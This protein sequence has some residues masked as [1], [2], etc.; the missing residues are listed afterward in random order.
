M[1]RTLIIFT[2]SYPWSL[3]LED[4]F[5]EPELS[6]LA[7]RFP[8]IILIPSQSKGV[9][10]NT[11][12]TIEVEKGWATFL[13]HRRG[14][15]LLRTL[16]SIFFE[17]FFWQEL[18]RHPDVLY[19]PSRLRVLL[20]YLTSAKNTENWTR[21][22]LKNNSLESSKVVFFT[23]WFWSITTGLA[24]LK[25]KHPEILLISRAHGF[26]IYP[27]RHKPS[28]IPCREQTLSFT[29]RVF[30]TSDHGRKTVEQMFPLFTQKCM[31]APLGTLEPGFLSQRSRDEVVRI[32]SCSGM[33]PVKR[34]DRIVEGIAMFARQTHYRVEWHHLGS[35]PTLSMLEK[36]CQEQFP[37]NAKRIFPGSV[38]NAGVFAYYHDHP[39]DIFLNTSESEGGRPVAIMEALSCGIPAIAPAVGGIPEIINANVG[40]LLP[41]NPTPTDIAEAIRIV[42]HEPEHDK[43][44]IAARQ[45]WESQYMALRNA[46][47]FAEA[48]ASLAKN[49]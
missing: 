10:A 46:V 5:L 13:E 31:T 7:K 22:F 21:D 30:F 4:P 28:Y 20:G 2:E 37:S 32:V 18:F 48:V 16:G 14:I 27:Q 44:R 26:D 1:Q 3:A 41:A 23:Y 12:V 24:I 25:R 29:E 17:S 42:L 43:K 36:K 15:R 19:N 47:H 34:L 9:R 8:R 35:G 38:N 33:V 45:L 49:A 39:F 11:P 6:A 40:S